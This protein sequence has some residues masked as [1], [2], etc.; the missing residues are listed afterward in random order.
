MSACLG[1]SWRGALI[2]VALISGFG[3]T[4]RAS[5]FDDVADFFSNAP[6]LANRGECQSYARSA[7]RTAQRAQNLMC[8][9]TGPRYGTD[10]NAHYF[11]C[12]GVEP[13]TSRAEWTARNRQLETCGNYF[14]TAYT[15]GEYAAEAIRDNKLYNCGYTGP[16]WEGSSEKHRTDYLHIKIVQT[17]TGNHSSWPDPEHDARLAMIRQCKAKYSEKKIQFCNLY[18][19][20]AVESLNKFKQMKCVGSQ[21]ESRLWPSDYDTHFSWCIGLSKG[22]GRTASKASI[23]RVNAETQKHR[24]ALNA[25]ITRNELITRGKESPTN[26]LYSGP[27]RRSLEDF[28][29]VAPPS[30]PAKPK[31]TS[32]SGPGTGGIYLSKPG[33]GNSAMDRLTGGRELPSGGGGGI[34]TS[35]PAPRPSAGGAPPAQA[36]SAPSGGGIN[37]TRPSAPP[38]GGG[39]NTTKPNAPSYGGGIYLSR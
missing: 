20:E 19:T 26:K 17:D 18:A 31:P 8:P 16:R 9:L 12:M 6:E 4:A 23:E 25:C 24:D 39:I 38:S 14:I 37:T 28:S 2:S 1:F 3:E 32:N 35:R 5:F 11:W 27:N 7:V 36:V 29:K 10:E 13:E 30:A 34:S 22:V 15:Y 33:G 21:N